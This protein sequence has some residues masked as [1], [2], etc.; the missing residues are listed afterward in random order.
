VDP[1]KRGGREKLGRVEKWE[2]IIRIYCMRKSSVFSTK[3]K[4]KK[5][6]D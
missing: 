3:K 5:K 4:M 2:T 6:K 1:E